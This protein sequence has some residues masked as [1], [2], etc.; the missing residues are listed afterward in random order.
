MSSLAVQ[1]RYTPKEYLALERKAAYKS[2]YV[3]GYIVAMAGASRAHNLVAGNI[4]REVNQQLRGRPCEAYV[5]DMRVRV[6]RV[7]CRPWYKIILKLKR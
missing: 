4:Y 7:I 1:P 3:N 5:S 6:N 2:E